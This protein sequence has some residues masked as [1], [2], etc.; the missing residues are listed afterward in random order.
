MPQKLNL[1]VR[2]IRSIQEK[3]GIANLLAPTPEEAMKMANIDVLSDIYFEGTRR[4]ENAP[5]R[6]QIEDLTSEEIVTAV[7]GLFSAPGKPQ[8]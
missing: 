1:T 8:A 2:Q 3:H 7:Q 5:T 4:H 6:E